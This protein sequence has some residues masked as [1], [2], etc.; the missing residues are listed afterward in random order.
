MCSSGTSLNTSNY[1]KRENI[2][3]A[4]SSVTLLVCE[5]YSD[6]TPVK[7]DSRLLG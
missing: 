1:P 5:A 2:L 3:P 4:Y 6:I 7:W